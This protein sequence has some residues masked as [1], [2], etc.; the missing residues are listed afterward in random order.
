MC[1]VEFCPS[2]LGTREAAD[3]PRSAAGLQ[4]AAKHSLASQCDGRVESTGGLVFEMCV[5]EIYSA[6]LIPRQ[7]MQVADL[8]SSKDPLDHLPADAAYAETP[9]HPHDGS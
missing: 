2:E 6:L 3:L 9:N 7:P 5:G 4:N 1:C 8:D